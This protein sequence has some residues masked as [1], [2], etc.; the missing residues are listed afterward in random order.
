MVLSINKRKGTLSENFDLK[1][2][3]PTFETEQLVVPPKEIKKES[4]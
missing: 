2:S 4:Y 1:L 3:D